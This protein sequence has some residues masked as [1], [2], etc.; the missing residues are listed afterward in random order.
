[1]IA[2]GAAFL[3]GLLSFATPCVLP[4][5]PVWLLMLGGASLTGGRPL[6][7][8]AC[9][10]LGFCLTFA[11]MGATA[12]RLGA[13]LGAHREL[14]RTLGGGVLIAF[15]LG[16]LGVL[17]RVERSFG[18]RVAPGADLPA[19][20]LAGAAFGCAWTPCLG[21]L[22]GSML[23]LAASRDTLLEGVS[24]LTAYGLGLST[25]LLLSAAFLERLRPVLEGLRRRGRAVEAVGGGLL[26]ALGGLLMGGAI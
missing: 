22:L 11:L 18:L 24:L 15:G 2:L 3:A 25:P 14:V 13:L 5:V 19:A 16:Y 1:M 6:R 26:V 7:A 8:M 17:P 4:L 21:P 10:C 23:L 12:S 20:L 9:F